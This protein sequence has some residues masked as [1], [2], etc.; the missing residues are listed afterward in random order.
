[1]NEILFRVHMDLKIKARYIEKTCFGF[2]QALKFFKS[3]KHF[4]LKMLLKL[5]MYYL[6]SI[7]SVKTI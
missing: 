1:M 4:E 3:L 5:L 6:I 7:V 2:C